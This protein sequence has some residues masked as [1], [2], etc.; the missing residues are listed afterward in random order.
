MIKIKLEDTRAIQQIS[1][2]MQAH[3]RTM[4][5]FYKEHVA[6]IQDVQEREKESSP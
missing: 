1:F 5:D 2:S 6:N 3:T 4:Q